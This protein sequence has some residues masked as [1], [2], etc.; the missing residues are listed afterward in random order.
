M[1]L[2]FTTNDEGKRVYSLKVCP[3]LLVYP[4]SNIFTQKITT[5]G[6]IT[7]SAHPARFSPD[8]KFSR[9]RVTIKK[10][11]GILPTQLPRNRAF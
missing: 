3:V 10:R 1:H 7:K 5:S 6:K 11:Y 8:D 9:H 4:Q 2:M